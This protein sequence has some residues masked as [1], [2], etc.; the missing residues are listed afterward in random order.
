MKSLDGCVFSHGGKMM[1]KSGQ[2]LL[3]YALT[4]FLIIGL[5]AAALAND[6]Y[7]EDESTFYNYVD[8]SGLRGSIDM[9][10]LGTLI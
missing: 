9:K 4:L 2:R 8:G 3:S 10:S 1:R 7:I 6:I 5:G